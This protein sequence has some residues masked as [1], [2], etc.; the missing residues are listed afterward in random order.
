MSVQ[1]SGYGDNLTVNGIRI[2]DLTPKEHEEIEKSNLIWAVVR[3]IS[4]SN[5]TVIYLDVHT[6]IVV[7][8]R[9]DGANWFTGCVFAM[10][11]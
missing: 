9:V 2:G 4:S 6:F 1:I 3:T 7:V 11:A 5:T 8:G 10:L